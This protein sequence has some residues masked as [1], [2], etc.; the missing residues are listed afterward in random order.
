MEAREGDHVDRQL[1]EVSV[2]LTR[3]PETGGDSRHGERDQVVEVTIRG[4][5]ELEVS[6]ADVIERLVI[7]HECLIRA[8]HQVMKSQ[9][10]IVWF[11]NSIRDLVCR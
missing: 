2:E 1:P 7:N 10:S 9:A 3:E 8:L 6:E 4:T 5:G 11:N